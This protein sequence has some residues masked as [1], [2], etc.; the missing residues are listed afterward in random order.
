MF[1]WANIEALHICF[2]MPEQHYWSQINCF[3]L[4]CFRWVAVDAYNEYIY[5]YDR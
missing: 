1:K 4:I 3:D 5:Y 2:A